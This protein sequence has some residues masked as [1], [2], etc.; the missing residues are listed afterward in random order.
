MLLREVVWREWCKY[1]QVP[2]GRQVIPM[3]LNDD[4]PPPTLGRILLFSLA[5]VLAV[6]LP[7]VLMKGLS[8]GDPDTGSATGQS[9]ATSVLTT[10]AGVFIGG[11]TAT[12]QPSSAAATA[13]SAPAPVAAGAATLADQAESCRLANLRQQAPLSAADVSLAQFDKHIDA[14]NLLVA[15]KISLSVATT[16]WDETRVAAADNARVFHQADKELTKTKADCRALDPAVANASPYGQVVVIMSCAKAIAARRTALARARTAVG[17]WEHHV[18]DMEMLR[19]G[20][21]SPAQATAAWHKNWK[22]GEKQ[23]AAYNKAASQA[24]KI[25]C[26]LN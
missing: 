15:G 14:M 21:L 8:G 25:Q 19:M 24:R 11:A 9:T 18:H 3:S 5:C 4:Q 23:L 20:H 6:A 1:W 7:V 22:T 13:S 10:G 16:F 17:T 2:R 26:S 12:T